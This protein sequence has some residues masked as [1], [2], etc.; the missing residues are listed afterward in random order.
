MSQFGWAKR[1]IVPLITVSGVSTLSTGVGSCQFCGKS[2][3]G[4]GDPPS[5]A[6]SPKTAP[7]RSRRLR[8]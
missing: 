6:D 1:F 7:A 2:D 4:A 3:S 5:A 8:S